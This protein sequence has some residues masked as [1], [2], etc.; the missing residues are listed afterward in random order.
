MTDKETTGI[1]W[2]AVIRYCGSDELTCVTNQDAWESDHDLHAGRYHPDDVLI[3][4]RGVQY[5][6]STRTGDTN[7]PKLTGETCTLAEIVAFV[8]AHVAQT[9]TCCV[10]KLYAASIPEA[11]ALLGA[12][13]ETARPESVIPE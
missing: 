9:G 12:T 10:S 11:I 1:I 2:P 13:E 5:A 8:R 6:L 7:L 3:D 4:A